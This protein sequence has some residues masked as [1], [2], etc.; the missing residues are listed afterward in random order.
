MTNQ[1]KMIAARP[2]PSSTVGPWAWLRTNLFSGPVNT[3]FTLAGLYLLYLLLAP[4]IQWAFIN[5][6]W[7]GTSRDDC[8]REGDRKSTRLNSSHVRISYAVFC[9]KKKTTK[10]NLPCTR[11]RLT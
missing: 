3:L 11:R 1:H 10:S 8:S 5:A 6:D 4:A 9:L 7:V 2:A